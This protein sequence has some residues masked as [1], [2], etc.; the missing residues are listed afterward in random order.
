MRLFYAAANKKNGIKGLKED[1][2]EKFINDTDHQKA[3]N[4]PE[5]VKFKKLKQRL[6]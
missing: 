6:I 4:L 3:S 2:A 1:T 5:K